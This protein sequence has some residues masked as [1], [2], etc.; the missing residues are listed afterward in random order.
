[1]K[2]LTDFQKIFW[3]NNIWNWA[4]WLSFEHPLPIYAHNC[5][6]HICH[7]WHDDA[8]WGGENSF[9]KVDDFYI[10]GPLLCCCADMLF[11][12]NSCG[13]W[14]EVCHWMWCTFAVHLVSVF[15]CLFVLLPVCSWKHW[16]VKLSCGWKPVL[17]VDKQLAV[18]WVDFLQES[19]LH[20]LNY[21]CV[22]TLH[23]SVSVLDFMFSILCVCVC[24]YKNCI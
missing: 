6:T 21:S 8:S 7:I 10:A 1:M 16:G 24:T 2:S 3:V 9:C 11:W 19:L 17:L 22:F 4:C 14:G 15:N 5:L 13:G 12:V 18:K 20:Q 23:D